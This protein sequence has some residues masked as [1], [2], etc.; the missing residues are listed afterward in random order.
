MTSVDVVIP[1]YNA[2][3]QFGANLVRFADYFAPYRDQY[4]LAYVIVDDAST[5]ATLMFSNAFAHHRGNVTV[6]RHMRRCGVGQ[7]LRTAFQRVGADYTIVMDRRL[8]CSAAA[9]M[10]LLETLEHTG[11]DVAVASPY[12]G[13]LP[14]SSLLA[15]AAARAL[16]G[17]LS[18]LAGGR[19]AGFTCML[20]AY[21]TTF[22]R[23]LAFSRTDAGAI[24]ELLF[25]AI[26][27]GGRI[28]VRPLVVCGE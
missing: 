1:A 4:D 3:P 24:P 27:A 7:A 17:L 13:H 28:I 18:I 6:L 25:S 14:Q 12:I 21:R 15:A 8:T 10:E 11:A 5:D 9:A 16:N 2:G 22:L 20:R 26:R 23:R 19:H